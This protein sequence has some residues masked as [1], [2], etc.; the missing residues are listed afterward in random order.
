MSNRRMAPVRVGAR[1]ISHGV[2]SAAG[3]HARLPSGALGV[4]RSAPVGN[5]LLRLRPDLS[6]A[7]PATFAQIV[8]L[9]TL[10]ALTFAGLLAS[11]VQP[12]NLIAL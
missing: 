11:I 6:A 1:Q 9:L 10:V 7:R 12:A 2:S 8:A 4:V 5:L 3:R